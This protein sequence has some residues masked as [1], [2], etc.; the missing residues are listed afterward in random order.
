MLARPR[1]SGEAGGKACHGRTPEHDC[2]NCIVALTR[3]A[4]CNQVGAPL[5]E[6]AL[7]RLDL[8]L[9]AAAAHGVRLILPLANFEAE[10]GGM[11]W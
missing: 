9:A 5:R 2:G 1:A 3:C 10:L 8:V 11:Q 4:S 6:E 7:R